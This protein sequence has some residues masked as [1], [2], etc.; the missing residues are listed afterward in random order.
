MRRRGLRPLEIMVK[1]LVWNTRGL[2]RHSKQVEV[3]IFISKNQIPYL[4]FW[5]LRGRFLKWE[6]FT[7]RC[8]MDGVLPLIVAFLIEEE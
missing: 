6:I 1:I 5:K 8:A 4:A 7:K 3:K 2:N